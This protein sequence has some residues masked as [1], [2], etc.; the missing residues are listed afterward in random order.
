MRFEEGEKFLNVGDGSL[1]PVLA[2]ETLQLIF[3]SS[4]VMLDD[5]HYYPFFM[6]NV[7]SVG[8]L[9]KLG[10]KFIIKDDFCD[11]IMNDTIIMCG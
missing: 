7:I 6:M 5:C 2:L 9:A 11:I 1:V 3:E 4:S 8:L 10:Y